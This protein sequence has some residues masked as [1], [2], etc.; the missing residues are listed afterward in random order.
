MAAAAQFLG[1]AFGTIR[2]LA[3][4]NIIKARAELDTADRRRWGFALEDVNAYARSSGA[5]V[6]FAPRR[7]I[8]IQKGGDAWASIR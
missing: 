7:R 8:R 4:L 5:V 2:K 1:K 6:R 3:D